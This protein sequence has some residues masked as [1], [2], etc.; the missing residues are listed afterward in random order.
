MSNP[1]QPWLIRYRYDPLDRLTGHTQSGNPER[2]RF[3]CKNRLATE[4]QG[5]IG[6]SIVQHGD[7]LL[8]QQQRHSD[9]LD[10][11]LLATDLQRSV[12]QSLTKDRQPHPI[13]YSPYGHRPAEN[14]LTSL[15]G[16]NGERPDAV[17]G[18]YLLGNGYRAF[19]P[20]LMRFNSPDS[21]SP[22]GKGGLNT[23][24]YCL[25]D[26]INFSDPN[27]H[28]FFVVTQL[29]RWGRRAATRVVA[30][31][32]EIVLRESIT[33]QSVA[34]LRPGI[35]PRQAVSARSK[36]NKIKYLAEIEPQNAKYR[37]DLKAAEK[38]AKAIESL[39]GIPVS[40]NQRLNLLKSIAVSEPSDFG[41]IYSYRKLNNIERG[42]YDPAT[43]I[44]GRPS[45]QSAKT[46][47]HQM[48][49]LQDSNTQIYLEE[50]N[51]LHHLHFQD[52]LVRERQQIRTE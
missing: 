46:Y 12:L 13:T 9:G 43:P 5:A 4:I 40:G 28:S 17:T 34:K 23:Y 35:T 11:T 21:W 47:D 45:Q 38:H 3:Y 52:E 49:N 25:G 30:R 2:H 10:T 18:H 31:S 16:F 27:G 8:A 6:H 19:N 42:V 7:L 26:P 36:I 44:F 33:S 37:S 50:E 14:G 32:S 41:L 20:V 24:T 1:Q 29:V 39:T 48:I 51:R 15:L 22:F